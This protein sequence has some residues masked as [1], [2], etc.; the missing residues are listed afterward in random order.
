METSEDARTRAAE[1]ISARFTR[2]MNAT[3][4][5]WGM[6]TD[7]SIV[8]VVTAPIVVALVA[9]V[10]V[11][12][13]PAVITAL[14]ALAAVPLAIAVGTVLAQRGARAEV[15]GWLAGLPFPVENMNAVLNG[16]GESLEVTFRAAAPGVKELNAVL[17]RVSADCFVSKGPDDTK[18][19]AVVEMRIG[20][21][22]E[23][24]NPSV[25]NHRRY[26]RVQALVA[27]VLVPLGEEHPIVEVRVK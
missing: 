16:L 8:G 22:D 10:R 23:K 27:E 17:E 4:S 1:S 6:F 15:V 19:P 11:E 26:V 2:V 20:V 21:V 3:P 24:R 5:R 25:S 12:A 7:P 14:Q 9:A 18:D 13:A